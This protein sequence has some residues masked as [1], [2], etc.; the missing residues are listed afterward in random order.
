MTSKEIK[1]DLAR[2]AIE[3]LKS[4]ND[5]GEQKRADALRY[6]PPKERKSLKEEL[7]NEIAKLKD[8]GMDVADQ[9]D[10]AAK[11]LLEAQLAGQTAKA[12]AD[13]QYQINND[14]TEEDGMPSDDNTTSNTG[15]PATTPVDDTTPP[16]KTKEKLS[17]TDIGLALLEAQIKEV[18]SQLR[19]IGRH[20]DTRK[21]MKAVREMLTEAKRQQIDVNQRYGKTLRKW[22]FD[23][24]LRNPQDIALMIADIEWKIALAKNIASAALTNQ[25]GI[26]NG[27]WQRPKA[28]G[29]LWQWW[30]KN[31]KL[32]EKNNLIGKWRYDAIN[33]IP[34]APFLTADGN[35]IAK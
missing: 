16:D 20:T 8:S 12:T 25:L 23:M 15:T 17:D 11:E 14:A 30:W 33:K 4:A 2:Q 35:R 31:T 28:W 27:Q 21:L 18:K 5:F 13:L 29:Q 1:E 24:D 34:N 10:Q 19:P 6:L 9:T 7:K 32:S 26:G 22:R 3:D